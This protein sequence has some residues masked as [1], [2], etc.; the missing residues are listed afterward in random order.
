MI[1]G[2]RHGAFAAWD[3][4]FC[5][6]ARLAICAALLPLL[7]GAV[8][9]APAQAASTRPVVGTA[10][11]GVLNA[12]DFIVPI[13]KSEIMQVDQPFTELLVGNPKIAN[14]LALTDRTIYVLGQA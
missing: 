3:R 4:G 10:N 1:A 11:G 9:P 12:G 2:P 7:A 6:C 13:N 8:G 14:V 5:L